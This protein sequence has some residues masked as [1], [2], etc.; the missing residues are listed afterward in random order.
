MKPSIR[1]DQFAALDIRVGEIIAAEAPEWSH[2]LLRLTVEIGEVAPVEIYAGIKAVYPNPE[3]LV[4]TRGVFLVNLEPKKMGE[5]VSQG[6][7]LMADSAT[8]PTPLLVSETVA[9]GTEVR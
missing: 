8:G 9:P 6:M 7:M 5:A 2:K 4:G 1:Y 3:E